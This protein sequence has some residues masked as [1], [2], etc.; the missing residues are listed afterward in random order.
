MI[1]LIRLYK[2]VY[3]GLGVGLAYLTASAE[4]FAQAAIMLGNVEKLAHM[5]EV[6][7][8][9]GQIV[10]VG[11]VFC[12]ESPLIAIVKAIR[13]RNRHVKKEKVDRAIGLHETS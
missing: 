8:G 12:A 3:I 13:M 2:L 5:G 6:T 4:H 11:S 7:V 10:D 1:K 9:Q